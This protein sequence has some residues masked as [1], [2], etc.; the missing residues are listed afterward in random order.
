MKKHILSLVTKDHSGWVEKNDY[1]LENYEEIRA[2]A[3]IVVKIKQYM[4]EKG[5]K[6]NELATL[7]DVTPQYVNK[8]L[9]GQ[10]KNIGVGTLLK[11]SKKLNLKLIEIPGLTNAWQKEKLAEKN[12]KYTIELKATSYGARHNLGSSFLKYNT[13]NY[14]YSKCN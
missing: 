11:Y 2:N 1:D 6:Q 10:V 8:L 12:I 13:Q 5:L 9:H 3:Y 7:L 4:K 14:G